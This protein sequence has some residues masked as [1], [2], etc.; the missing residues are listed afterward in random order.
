MSESPGGPM[1]RDAKPT[2]ATAPEQGMTRL[3]T[4]VDAAF[5]FSATMLVLNTE[6]IPV[7]FGELVQALKGVPSFAAS[8]AT[9][10]LFWAS[11]RELTR[12]FPRENA[13]TVIWSLVLIG[14][15]LVFVYPLKFAYT[16]G[17][18]YFIPALRT[19]DFTKGIQ[20]PHDIAGMFMIYGAGFGTFHLVLM[21]LFRHQVRSA[22]PLPEGERIRAL[23]SACAHLWCA[24][25]AGLSIVIASMVS[26]ARTVFAATLP[27][28]AYCLLAVLMPWH[29]SRVE[30]RARAAEAPLVPHAPGG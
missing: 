30:R 17:F 12:R 7:S 9:L 11:H 2:P 18:A 4:F 29:W 21:L 13:G 19:A 22:G 24:L 15:T 23:G 20:G 14:V 6:R 26:G 10:A 3:E 27:G 16:Q 25:I 8:F 28:F 5:A 1:S